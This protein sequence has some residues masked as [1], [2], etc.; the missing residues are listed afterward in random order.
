MSW[1]QTLLKNTC[2]CT[3]LPK[4][5]ALRTQ[6]QKLKMMAG[7]QGIS[8]GPRLWQETFWCHPLTLVGRAGRVDSTMDLAKRNRSG[9]KFHEC[10]S[11]TPGVAEVGDQLFFLQVKWLQAN[12]TQTQN[13]LTLCPPKSGAGQQ[14]P[15]AASSVP[16]WHNLPNC[17]CAVRTSLKSQ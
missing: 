1:A 3:T 13:I 5:P 11:P 9:G 2:V 8:R 16:R 17:P 14:G 12:C 7:I 15:S 10:A 4:Y 6:E